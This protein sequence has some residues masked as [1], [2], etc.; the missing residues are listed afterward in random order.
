MK[1]R[2]IIIIGS[3]VLIIAGSIGLSKFLT[4][5]KE[6]PEEK[7]EAPI[8]KY[9][10]TT[11]VEYTDIDTK[12][13]VYGRV[14]SAESLD[15]IAEISGIM[16]EGAI[17]L[18]PGEKF[19]KGTLIYNIDDTEAK[20]KLQAQKSNFLSDLATILPDF[21][22]DY[23]ESFSVWQNY[24]NS[25]DLEKDLPPLPKRISSKEK[26]FLATKNIFNSYY[27]IKSAE[28][29]MRKYKVYAPFNG[30]ISEVV[31][32]SGS[33]VNPGNKVARIIRT[34]K[35]ELEVAIEVKDVAWL[36]EGTEVKIFSETGQQS[37]KGNI[38]RIG[39]LVNQNTQSIDV[40]ISISP[41]QYRIYDG[42]YL[43]AEIPGKKVKN[44]MVIPRNAIFN[45]TQ[46]FVVA[47]TLLKVRDIQIHKINPESVVFSGLG[48]GEDLVVEPLINAHNNMR[49]W[50]LSEKE[51]SSTSVTL[52]ANKS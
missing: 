51:S 25:I 45:G 14:K 47:D 40:F 20:F 38:V 12:V 17:T 48:E 13:V 42:L 36:T 32:Q 24:F 27:S 30:S 43:R 4:S 16:T 50:K 11:K 23:P 52:T 22:I 34:D 35:L 2:Q 29:N 18:K 33:Y 6:E 3:A 28:A 10:K 15:L 44:S 9:V 26:T 49:V 8:R 19:T 21:K 7:N 39:D 1:L 41:N 31:L 46:V 5:L 37:W